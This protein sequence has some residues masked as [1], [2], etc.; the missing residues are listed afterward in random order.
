MG[1][2][3]E[4]MEQGHQKEEGF[5]CD[6]IESTR[7]SVTSSRGF[8][9]NTCSLVRYHRKLWWGTRSQPRQFEFER[10]TGLGYALTFLM[11]GW[12]NSTKEVLELA[13]N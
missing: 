13:R 4:L 10:Q 12:R 5:G 8:P 9:E 11:G 1:V 3:V 7:M 2:E 6:L